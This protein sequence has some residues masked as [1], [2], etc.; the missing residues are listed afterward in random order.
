MKRFIPHKLLSIFGVTGLLF[1]TYTHIAHAQVSA[2]ASL[3]GFNMTD[4]VWGMASQVSYVLL[5][6]AS[7][8]LTATGVLLNV[9]LV[10]TLNIKD[11]V[12]N[13]TGV[14][15]IW[16]AI[17]DLSGTLIIFLVLWAAF[18]IIL[19]IETQSI[20]KLLKNIIVAGVLI[21]FSFFLTGLLIDASNLVSSQIYRQ[22]IPEI[23]VNNVKVGGMASLPDG[24]KMSGQ[25]L[26]KSVVTQT[27]ERGGI[28]DIFMS[29]FNLTQIYSNNGQFKEGSQQSELAIRMFTVQMTGAIAMF[30]AGFS[31]I[32]ASLAFLYR[33]AIL[34][35][36]LAFSPVFFAAAIIPNLDTHAKRGWSLFKGQL[37]FMPVYLLLM[38]MALKIVATGNFTGSSLGLIT[39]TGTDNDF[40]LGIIG[41]IANF[42][43]VII[44]LLIPLWGA[45]SIGGPATSFANNWTNTMRKWSVNKL[46]AGGIGAWRGTGGRLASLTARSEGF[47][48]LA[49]SN[50]I[51]GLAFKSVRGVAGGYEEKLAKQVKSKTDF[52]TSLGQDK[53]LVS[54]AQNRLKNLREAQRLMRSRGEEDKAKA[55]DAGIERVKEELERAKTSRQE[56]FATTTNSKTYQTVWTKVAR[57]DK[58]AAAKI[59]GEIIKKQLERAQKSLEKFQEKIKKNQDKID[60]FNEG[61]STGR[62]KDPNEITK[63]K[64]KIKELAD[65][66]TKARGDE[67]PKIADVT[68]LEDRLSQYEFVS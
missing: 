53:Y 35:F 54:D 17:R 64:G 57:K 58:V 22:M 48:D 67:G 1:V 38:Y 56:T 27:Y 36:I 37:I 8:F 19:G 52:A 31:F 3:F 46:K 41:L 25:A 18:Q 6:L 59:E 7:F 65:K 43:F 21:N 51:A 9:S 42:V 24:Q 26:V 33:L 34:I 39:N 28:T 32:F 4:F 14:Y 20:G 60:D 66:I 29:A 40:W 2:V 55:M 12:T 63:T 44:L 45:L 68:K 5:T 62:I 47:R 13:I 50:R 15:E 23:V 61:L 16:L 10:L 30:I 49:A 11:F